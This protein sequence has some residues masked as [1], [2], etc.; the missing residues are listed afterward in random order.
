MLVKLATSEKTLHSKCTIN[1]M[2]GSCQTSVLL[3]S[4]NKVYVL[5]SPV[6]NALKVQEK[7]KFR[8]RMLAN[9]DIPLEDTITGSH[10]WSFSNFSVKNMVS[11]RK[12]KW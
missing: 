1:K 3:G 4:G 9:S 12:G 6:Q 8:H 2:N 7:K 11:D 10:L 5:T